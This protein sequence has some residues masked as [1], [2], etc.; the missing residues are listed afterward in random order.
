MVT[1]KFSR[2]PP[3]TGTLMNGAENI[4]K[5]KATGFTTDMPKFPKKKSIKRV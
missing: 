5:M 2:F 3:T 1:K 4:D